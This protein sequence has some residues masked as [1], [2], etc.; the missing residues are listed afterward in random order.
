MAPD[1]EDEEMTAYINT[2]F[3]TQRV[4][5]MVLAAGPATSK[6]SAIAAELGITAGVVRHAL[7][8]LEKLRKVERTR[9]RGRNLSW[10]PPG[11]IARHQQKA[12]ESREA[13]RQKRLLEKREQRA[14]ER[15]DDEVDP[16]PMRR[17]IV[18]AATARPLVKTCPASVWELG[19]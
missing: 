1:E 13:Y 17:V 14:L 15:L 10:G 16:L 3:I 19:R 7:L 6:A 18:P 4:L 12:L 9:L 8:K 11:T 2:E 5:D